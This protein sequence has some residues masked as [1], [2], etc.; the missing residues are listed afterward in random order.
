MKKMKI[1][2]KN[3][4]ERGQSEKVTWFL[5]AQGTQ[6]VSVSQWYRD[7]AKPDLEAGEILQVYIDPEKALASLCQAEISRKLQNI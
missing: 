2:G 7:R 1:W 3:I 5:K 4:Q 6:N